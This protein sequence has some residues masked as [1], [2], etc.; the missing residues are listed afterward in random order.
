MARRRKRSTHHHA[1]DDQGDAERKRG[2]DANRDDEVQSRLERERVN[3]TVAR[4]AIHQTSN[5]AAGDEQARNKV[6]HDMHPIPRFSRVEVSFR[7]GC[8]KAA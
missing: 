1:G 2:H 7:R 3:L 5:A 8:A 4:P 6:K